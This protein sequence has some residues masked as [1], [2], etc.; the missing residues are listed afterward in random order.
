MLLSYG[1]GTIL[2]GGLRREP[3]PAAE[4]LRA[5]EQGRHPS[6][7]LAIRW[8]TVLYLPLIPLGTYRVVKSKE[9]SEGLPITPWPSSQDS[10]DQGGI[11][12]RR[13]S[14]RWDLVLLQLT[15]VWGAAYVLF[16][17][18][19]PHFGEVIFPRRQR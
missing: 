6:S 18:V 1:I 11:D 3:L 16:Q 9:L 15:L 7:F 4:A 5:E 10:Q 14:W 17:Y 2:Y 13:V 19:L 8:F 12:V